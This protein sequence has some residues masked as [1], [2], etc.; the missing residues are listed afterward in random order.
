MFFYSLSL[1]WVLRWCS[2]VELRPVSVLDRFQ[3]LNSAMNLPWSSFRGWTEACTCPGPRFTGWT[4]SCTCPGPA[5]QV[6]L[7]PVPVL[8][9]LQRLNL[10][11][12]LAWSGF[13]GWTELC[14]C[15]GPASQVE[16]S[17]VPVLVRVHRLNWALYRSG[18]NLSWSRLLADSVLLSLSLSYSS[19][20]LYL[21]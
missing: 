5:S 19:L 10:A 18:L 7:S 6:E 3:R 20:S 8:V 15:P 1:S 9:Q 4:E 12:Y 2:E 16:L 17:S 13:T 14:T 11:L 21:K